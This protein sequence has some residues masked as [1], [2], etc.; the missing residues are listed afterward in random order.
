M[1]DFNRK[2]TSKSAEEIEFDELNQQH[3]ANILQ[4]GIGFDSQIG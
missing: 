4:R 3:E 2:P 1:I